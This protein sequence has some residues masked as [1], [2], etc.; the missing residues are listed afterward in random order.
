VHAQCF[1]AFCPECREGFH[2]QQPCTDGA[3]RLEEIEAQIK[4]MMDSGGGSVNASK[5]TELE[6][7]RR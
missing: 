7:L 5:N 3:T 2:G 6:K 1:Y 4:R